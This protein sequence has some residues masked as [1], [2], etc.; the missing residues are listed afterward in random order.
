MYILLYAVQLAHNYYSYCISATVTRLP[1]MSFIRGARALAVRH[2]LRRAG[3]A[4]RHSWR[5]DCMPSAALLSGALLLTSLL[6]PSQCEDDLYCGA[7][8]QSHTTVTNWSA[9][10]S[11]S[12]RKLFEPSSTQEVRHAQ[13]VILSWCIFRICILFCRRLYIFSFTNR[14]C[15]YCNS[16]ETTR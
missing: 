14:L 5:P 10:H 4:S 2:S 12:A 3:P 1:F 13:L 9:T 8:Y 16:I 6:A 7:E 11:C 15:A